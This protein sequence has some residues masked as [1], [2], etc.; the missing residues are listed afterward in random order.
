MTFAPTR[1]FVATLL[2]CAAA[3]AMAQTPPAAP[4][5]STG[6]AMHDRM[7]Q[8]DPAKMKEHMA[9]RQAELKAKLAITATQEPAWATWTA[10]VQPTAAHPTRPSRED[11]AKLNTPERIDKM[12]EM[13]GQRQAEM[14]KRADATKAFY[15]SLTADQKKVFDAETARF[16]GGMGRNSHGGHGGHHGM[17][18]KG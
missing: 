1:L 11:I 16:A 6:H 15:N 18:H 17:N 9:K 3:A 10:A 14:D 2:A 7:G 8:R 5:T 12:R 4:A 13:R